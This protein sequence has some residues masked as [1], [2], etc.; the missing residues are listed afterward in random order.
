MR[1]EL[2]HTHARNH[3]VCELLH[4]APAKE[5]AGVCIGPWTAAPDQ[6]VG[7][8]KVLGSQNASQ[9]CVLSEWVPCLPQ[10]TASALGLLT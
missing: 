5:R 10:D 9:P 2:D 3:T 1:R 6:G 4:R 7:R 8:Q